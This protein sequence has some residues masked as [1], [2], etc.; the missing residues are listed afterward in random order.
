MAVR[1]QEGVRK[2]GKGRQ[3]RGERGHYIVVLFQQGSIL[4]RFHDSKTV[5][6]ARIQELTYMSLWGMFINKSH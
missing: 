5:P 4:L 6:L 3:K 2:R 1:K